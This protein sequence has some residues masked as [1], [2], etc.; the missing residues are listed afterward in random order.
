MVTMKAALHA[1]ERMREILRGL[2]G[3][4]G[5]GVTWDAEGRPCV[6]VNIDFEIKE[7][8]RRKIPSRIGEVPVLV[9]ETGQPQME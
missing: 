1:K 7:S 5:I 2:P 6:R 8:D 9:E 3:I 4:N